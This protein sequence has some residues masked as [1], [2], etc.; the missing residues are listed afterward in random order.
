MIEITKKT[1]DKIFANVKPSETVKKET[2]QIEYFYNKELDQ[3]GKKI[4]NF[5]SS[6]FGNFYLTDI[7]A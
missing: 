4:Y 3:R 6:T 5:V 7:N 2:Y 1:F